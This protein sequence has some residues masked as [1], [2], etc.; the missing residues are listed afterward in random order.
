MAG[1]IRLKDG[2]NGDDIPAFEETSGCQLCLKN[3]SKYTCPRCNVKYCSLDCYRGRKHVK[4]SESFYKDCVM[5]A[6]QGETVDDEGKRRMVEVLKRFKEE[7]TDDGLADDE[8]ELGD[9]LEERLH[10][11]NLD[12]DTEKVWQSLTDAERKEFQRAVDDGYIGALVDTWV[13]WWVSRDSRWVIMG[14]CCG[15]H[16]YMGTLVV[17]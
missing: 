12:R 7:E 15:T 8:L 13:P 1:N 2:E 9:N 4:C 17:C 5:D 6:L 14:I 11:L 16:G 3:A 10:G